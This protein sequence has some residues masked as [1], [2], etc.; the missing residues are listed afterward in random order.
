MTQPSITGPTAGTFF[1]PRNVDVVL[2]AHAAL[3]AG[4]VV[5]L[6]EDLDGTTDAVTVVDTCA[7]GNCGI[8]GVAL[9]DVA[10]GAEGKFRFAGKVGVKLNNATLVGAGLQAGAS[11]TLTDSL[12][13]GSKVVGLALEEADTDG[14]TAGTLYSV[15][16]DG[17]NGF[18]F[19]HS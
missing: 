1:I 17:I 19:N 15:A 8:I 16:L 2:T 6:A 18:G 12:T 5:S 13:A 11:F 4:Q 9:E 10:S 7:G 3:T 14:T